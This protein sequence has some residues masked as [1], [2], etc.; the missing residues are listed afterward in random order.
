MSGRILRIMSGEGASGR[1]LLAATG[2]PIY[3]Q[4]GSSRVRSGRDG[5]ETEIVM[6]FPP[7]QFCALVDPVGS[8]VKPL[9]RGGRDNRHLRA[10]WLI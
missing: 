1:A 3:P 4:R 7:T 9:P 10:A 6:G 5:P 2:W 8:E